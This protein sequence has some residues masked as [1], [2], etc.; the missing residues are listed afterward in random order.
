MTIHFNYNKKQVIQALRYHFFTRPEIKL[1]FILINVFALTSAV[2]FYFKL[3]QA[4]SFL[5]FSI[6]WFFLMLIIWRVLPSSIYKKSQTFKE[7]FTLNFHDKELSLV[8]SRGSRSWQWNEI[9]YFI[10]SPYF[11]HLYFDPKSFFLVPKDAMNGEVDAQDVR[12]FLKD[13]V[14]RK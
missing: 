13:R 8:T 11:F 9:S 10:E 4:I 2:L 6:L 1:L 7:E 12:V 5:V 3:I 14:K